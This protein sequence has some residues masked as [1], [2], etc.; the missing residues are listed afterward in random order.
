[1]VEIT[2]ELIE[3]LTARFGR[4]RLCENQDGPWRRLGLAGRFLVVSTT[5]RT[6][7][8]TLRICDDCWTGFGPLVPVLTEIYETADKIEEILNGKAKQW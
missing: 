8:A 1:V 5:E 3:C 2:P 6:W 7:P 4:C